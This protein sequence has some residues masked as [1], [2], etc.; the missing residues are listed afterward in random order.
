ME[1]LAEGQGD[2]ADEHV[3]GGAHAQEDVN[4]KGGANGEQSGPGKR[5]PIDKVVSKLAAQVNEFSNATKHIR[6][7]AEAVQTIREDMESLKRQNTNEEQAPP[8]KKTCKSNNVEQNQPGSSKI[9]DAEPVSDDSESDDTEDELEA[10]ME[11]GADEDDSFNELEEFFQTDDGTGEEVGEK[12]AKIT[13]KAVR[14]PKSKKDE[15]NLQA[16]KQKHLRPKNIPNLQA[17]KIDEFLWRQLKRDVKKADY[18]Q[19]TAVKNYAQ[20][21]TPLIKALDLMQSNRDPEIT[22]KHV[23]DSFKILSLQVKTTNLNRLEQVKKELHPKYK[24]L[25]PE[26]PSEAKLLGDS[27]Q[28][29]VKKLEGTKNNITI[30]S[31]SFLGKRGGDRNQSS[32]GNNRHKFRQNQNHGYRNQRNFRSDMNNNNNNMRN[33]NNYRKK[34]NNNNNSRK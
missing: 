16:L 33:Q 18:L 31:Q 27:F 19:Q 3:A 15:E 13:Q 12:M 29:A 34:N 6:T 28:D 9:P 10:L 21:M 32:Q 23:M 1:N 25:V 24:A 30:S 22:K 14:G 11:Q 8:S 20:A 17:P 7:L 4:E 26:E 2:H 5:S